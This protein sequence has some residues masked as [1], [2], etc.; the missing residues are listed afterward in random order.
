C[1]YSHC[2]DLAHSSATETGVPTKY[3]STCRRPVNDVVT[4]PIAPKNTGFERG[5][6]RL[7]GYAAEQHNAIETDFMS[8]VVDN[9]GAQ[10]MQIL[11]AGDLARLTPEL[12][13][14]WVRFIMALHVRHPVRVDQITDQVAELT[15]QSLAANPEEYEAV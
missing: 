8:A 15:R 5:L 4:H 3:V 11:I 2:F 10:A 9:E 13:R 1:S 14:A 6:Y 12:G 7:D